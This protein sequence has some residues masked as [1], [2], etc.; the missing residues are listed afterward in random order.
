LA[1]GTLDQARIEALT[2]GLRLSYGDQLLR[3]S[4]VRVLIGVIT[5]TAASR[6]SGEM[7][8]TVRETSF[9]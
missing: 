7:W 4:V 5:T 1:E 9:G 2:A 6:A 8:Y 3:E